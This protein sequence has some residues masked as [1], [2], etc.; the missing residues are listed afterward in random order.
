MKLEALLPPWDLPESAGFSTPRLQEL[1]AVLEREVASQKLPGGVYTIARQGRLVHARCFGRLD[2]AQDEPMPFDAIFRIYSMTKPIVSMAAMMLVER[3][4]ASLDEPV[5]RWLPELADLKVAAAPLGESTA[6]EIRIERPVTL[7]NLLCHTAGFG[8]DFTVG[9]PLRARYAA[10]RLL[11]RNRTNAEFVAELAKLPLACQPG[12]AWVYGHS[13][14]VLGRLIEVLS[15]Q[16][17]GDFLKAQIFE[18]L[19]MVDTAFEVDE[20]RAQRLAEPFQRDPDTGGPVHVFDVRRRVR[21]QMAGAGLVSTAPDH[22]RFMQTV[23]GGGKLGE[24]RLLSRETVDLMTVDHLG[25]IPI[26][27]TLLSPG[28][29]FGL[30]FAVRRNDGLAQGAGS[31]GMCSWGGLAGT[32]FF[33]DAREGLHAQLMIQQPGRR[34]HYRELFRDSVYAAML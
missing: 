31:V 28:H 26:T 22:A 6:R 15:G 13:T 8:Y 25:A 23:L 21:H 34:D 16:D 17:L 14:D 11:S 29:G 5:D 4:L 18:P 30:G 19:G 33:I 7:K 9:G 10:A 12:S 20:T 27:S 1:C 24:V 3:G 2:P 32:S